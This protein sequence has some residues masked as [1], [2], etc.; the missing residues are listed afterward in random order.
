MSK[1]LRYVGIAQRIVTATSLA[2]PP[3]CPSRYC[4]CCPHFHACHQDAP[5]GGAFVRFSLWLSGT[6][7]LFLARL[8]TIY[9]R[10]LRGCIVLLEKL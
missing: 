9:C 10:G 8:L 3:E 7:D 4:C 6:L 5:L 1:T 2:M